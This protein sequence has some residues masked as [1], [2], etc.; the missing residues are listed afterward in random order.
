MSFED[1]N[2]N[3]KFILK[4]ID[5]NVNTCEIDIT[6]V[7]NYIQIKKDNYIQIKKDNYIQI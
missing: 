7:S 6:D 4:I 5:H 2:K 3:D 1:I